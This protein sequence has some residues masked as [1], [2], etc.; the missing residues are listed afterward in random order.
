MGVSKL[1]SI[2]ILF[3]FLGCIF[4]LSR[5]SKY[6]RFLSSNRWKL[7]P[8][9]VERYQDKARIALR[10]AGILFAAFVGFIVLSFI[11]SCFQL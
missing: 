10:N 2:A 3:S 7:E 1:L 4:M 11:A 9:E 6:G 8:E 5:F